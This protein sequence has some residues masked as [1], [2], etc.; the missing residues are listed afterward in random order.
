MKIVVVDN[1]RVSIK[2]LTT[3]LEDNGHEV[4]GFL[5]SAKAL[6]HIRCDK[7]V[8]VLLTGLELNP[9]S[10]F[11]LCWDTR[12]LVSRGRQ[13]YI[14]AMSSSAEDSKLI[15]TLDSG[16]DDFIRKPPN[17]QELLARLRVAERMKYMQEELI[18][19]ATLDCLTGILNR[20]AFFDAA[21]AHCA[22]AQKGADLSAIMFDI[23]HFKKVN[24]KFGHDIGDRTL[25]DV[26]GT[27]EKE[28]GLFARMGGEEFALLLPNIAKEGALE[29]AEKLRAQVEALE[30]ETEDKLKPLKVTCSFGVSEWTKGDTIESLLKRSDLALYLS[31][32]SGRNQVQFN[33]H[34]TQDFIPERTEVVEVEFVELD[35]DVV[36][37]N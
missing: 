1:S 25:V 19:L 16:A 14:L 26:V 7:D 24:D 36:E 13:I 8:D 32:E 17:L 20:R 4:I 34:T 27:V 31:K 37:L 6:S 29:I 23:D 22:A 12:L 35:P 2:I 21:A 11:E 5:D 9:S 18:K 3:M 15:E 10:G 30:I 33:K 28:F